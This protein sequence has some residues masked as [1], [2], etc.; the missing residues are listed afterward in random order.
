MEHDK[1]TLKAAT[2]V[3][4]PGALLL[5]TSANLLKALLLDDK[6]VRYSWWPKRWLPWPKR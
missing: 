4:Y 1:W 3:V 2:I 6:R 5:V